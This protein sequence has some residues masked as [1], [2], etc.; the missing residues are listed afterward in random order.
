MKWDE[1]PT[2]AKLLDTGDD[3]L[4][5]AGVEWISVR[6]WAGISREEILD[7]ARRVVGLEGVPDRW[8]FAGGPYRPEPG[9]PRYESEFKPGISGTDDDHI[10]DDDDDGPGGP[11][12]ITKKHWIMIEMIGMDD[13]PVPDEAYEIELPDGTVVKGKLDDEGKATHD[14]P[15]PGE[16]LVT[17]P[18]LDQD[19]WMRVLSF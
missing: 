5:N 13:N 4:F 19:A 10:D 15:T 6:E 8:R 7:A 17:F 14:S 12:G 9:L 16:C 18:D 3:V 11:P 2:N 1:V